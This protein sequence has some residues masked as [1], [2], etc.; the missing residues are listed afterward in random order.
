MLWKLL[1]VVGGLTFFVNGFGVLTDDQCDSVSFSGVR[2][3]TVTCYS[4]D[5]GALPGWLG[6]LGMVAFGALMILFA[7]RS[8]LRGA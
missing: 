6:G 5:Y 4:G 7:V 1:A 8:W 3:V 2:A